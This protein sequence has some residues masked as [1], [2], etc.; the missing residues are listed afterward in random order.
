MPLLISHFLLE[1]H[2]PLAGGETA[3]ELAEV[4]PVPTGGRPRAGRRGAGRD[5]E[6]HHQ[7]RRPAEGGRGAARGSS[8]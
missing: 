1:R 8:R 6:H 4:R 3:A 5:E 7:V 2:G